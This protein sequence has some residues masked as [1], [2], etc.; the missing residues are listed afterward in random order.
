MREEEGNSKLPSTMDN[1]LPFTDEIPNMSSSMSF[2]LPPTMPIFDMLPLLPQS[3][4]E[5]PK[6]SNYG[7]FMDLL[8]F[9]DYSSNSW[10]DWPQNIVPTPEP[11]PPQIPNPPPSLP[12]P[13]VAD[14]FEV[15]NTLSLPNSSSNEA[16]ANKAIKIETEAKDLPVNAS[17]KGE[18]E[19]RTKN[20]LKRTVT[21]Y[22][23]NQSDSRVAFVTK[24]EVDCIDDGYKWRKY[25]QKDVKNNPNPRSYYRCTATGCS[26]KKRVERCAED[27]SLV[28]TTYD[29]I[30]NHS[31]PIPSPKMARLVFGGS[32][33]SSGIMVYADYALWQQQQFQRQQELEQQALAAA[34]LYNS[35]SSSPLNVVN[36]SS[37]FNYGN[38]S[39]FGGNDILQNQDFVSSTVLNPPAFVRDNGLLQDMIMQTWMG[40][41]QGN[42][43]RVV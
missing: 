13:N 14:T 15:V 26:V 5:D 32:S 16:F 35:I 28:K 38:A 39:A 31:R 33:T 21:K 30:H 22:R 4:L 19:E 24:S 41:D 25:G 7:D 12:S 29:G 1:I 2:P 34:A 10:F 3:S 6:A 42:G 20:L 17:K 11:P 40:N 23:K 36:A 9:P 27:S 37:C 8:G 18:D 43:D